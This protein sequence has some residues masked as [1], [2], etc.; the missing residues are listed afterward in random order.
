V[1]FGL[2]FLSSLVLGRAFFGWVCPAGGLQEIVTNFRDR[3]VRRRRIR[4]IKFL[5]WVPWFAFFIFLVLKAG[6]IREVNLTW[7][8]QNGISVSDTH[9][10]IIYLMIILIFVVL[11]ATVGRRAGCHALCWMAPFMVIGRS[12][13]NTIAWPSLRLITEK[14]KCI[15]C[16]SCTKACQMSIEVMDLVQSGKIETLDCILCGSCVDACPKKVIR[17]AF[18]SGRWA[19]RRRERLPPG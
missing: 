5:I 16:G 2:Q 3:A 8:T 12:I 4:W 6:G 9:S 13:R 17:F 14:E 18:R 15:Q 11:S 19:A 1:I 10:L 7:R